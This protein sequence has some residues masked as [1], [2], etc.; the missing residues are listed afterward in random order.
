MQNSALCVEC[1]RNKFR[2]ECAPKDGE[3]QGEICGESNQPIFVFC[4][5]KLDFMKKKEGYKISVL[6]GN[7]WISAFDYF[8]R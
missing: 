1:D 4:S 8:V 7:I 5:F 3:L 2:Q 6:L